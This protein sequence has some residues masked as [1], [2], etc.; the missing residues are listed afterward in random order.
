MQIS[1]SLYLI[2]VPL[3]VYP[4]QSKA[5]HFGLP[6]EWVDRLCRVDP[7]RRQLLRGENFTSYVCAWT[8]ISRQVIGNTDTPP[9]AH[10]Q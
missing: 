8:V 9:P 4:L 3:P 2:S 1:A 7:D 6:Q 5:L 10:A